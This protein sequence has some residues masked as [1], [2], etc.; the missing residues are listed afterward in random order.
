MVHALKK[1]HSLLKENG[2]LINIH[3]LGEPPPIEVRLGDDRHHV[4]WLREED[5]YIEYVQAS[6]AIQTVIDQGQFF[7]EKQDTF[8]YT[9]YADALA[10]LQTY[11]EKEWHDAYIEDVVAGRIEALMSSVEPDQ[12]IILHDV[13]QISRLRPLPNNKP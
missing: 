5:D 6:E 11:L 13:I 7:R 12:E 4:G 8:A 1:A 9:I 3:P 2:R 10:D